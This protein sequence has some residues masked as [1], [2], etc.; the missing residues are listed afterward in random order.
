[1][2]FSNEDVDHVAQLARLGLDDDEKRRLGREL[3][4]IL[5][6][7]SKLQEVDTSEISETA[8]VGELINVWRD[9]VPA[10]CIGADLA[11]V[12]APVTDGAHFV[13]GAIQESERDT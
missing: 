9:D 3:T 8:Q 7:I 11:L 6:A 12:N 2:T 10:P 1:M 4:A 5:D 13:V